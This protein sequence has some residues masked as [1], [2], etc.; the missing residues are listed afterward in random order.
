MIDHTWATVKNSRVN[1]LVFASKVVI[2]AESLEV[3]MLALEAL[4]QEMKPLGFQV[5]LFGSLLDDTVHSVDECGKIIKM[6]E[7]F[8]YL[9]SLVLNSRNSPYIL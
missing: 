7:D 6:V 3:F 5:Q 1:G 9:I 2:L 8:T 4:H